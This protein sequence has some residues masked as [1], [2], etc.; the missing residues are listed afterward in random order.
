[1]FA[2]RDLTQ[3][4]IPRGLL[5]FA[6]P[7]ILGNLL[8]QLY[9]LAD[10]WVVGRFIGEGALAAVGSSYTLMTFL[11][12]ILLGL[13]MGS[14]VYF[15]IQYGRQDPD[16]LR[17]G[18]FQSFLLIGGLT[19]LLNLTVYLAL[20]GIL[21][22]LQIPPDI[23]GLTKEYLQW[24][25]A[26][27]AATFLY[28][29]FANLLRS[30]GDSATPLVFLGISVVLNIGLDIL[31]VVPLGMG[32]R[33]AAM[34]TV[35]AQFVAGLGLFL[36]TWF[37]FPAL[38]VQK[39]HR[40][41]DRAALKNLLN[42]SLFTCL[43]QSVMNFGILM[44][45]GLVNSF[46]TAVMAAFA[47]AVKIDTIAYMP[48][49]DFGNAFSTFVAQNYGAE[50]RDRIRTGTHWA[51]FWVVLFCL[52]IGGLVCLLAPRLMAAFVGGDAAE[53][54][55]IGTGYLRIEAAFYLGIGILFL[56]YGYFRAVNRPAVSVVLTICSLGTRVLLAYTLSALPALGVNGIWIAIPIGWFLADATGI[57]LWRR[58]GK[59]AKT[60]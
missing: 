20:D 25:F 36:Y 29:F 39:R 59:S 28:N 38:R 33:G 7:L 5:G 40:Y 57:L 16:R 32:V 43:Q 51:V 47:V 2:K 19:L 44:V 55:A 18:I 31:F 14:S 30:V 12:S 45:Q 48:V 9:N 8:Q 52:V 56:L 42:L 35:I 23:L 17:N 21:V 60:P 49:Q 50:K 24:V 34:A 3:G 11:T 27:M 37:A 15:S 54:I 13:C 6:L 58:E 4:S 41:W 22:L 1:M 53:V 46:G 26:G 10:T